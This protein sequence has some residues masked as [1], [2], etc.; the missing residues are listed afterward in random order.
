MDYW[1]LVDF[2]IYT[3]FCT[4][5]AHVLRDFMCAQVKIK[6]SHGHTG[7]YFSMETIYGP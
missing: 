7:V 1:I 4:C 5:F 3:H 2:D 6:G